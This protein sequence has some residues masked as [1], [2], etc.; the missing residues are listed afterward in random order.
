MI[1][2]I[3]GGMG[4]GK[5]TI[6]NIFRCLGYPVFNSDYEAKH[7]AGNSVRVIEWLNTYLGNS[8]FTNGVLNRAYIAD[9]LFNNQKLLQQ[10]NQLVHPLV[11]EKFEIWKENKQG[12]IFKESALLIESGAYKQT[13]QIIMVTSPV[14]LRIQRVMNRDNTTRE[15][16]MQRISKQMPD[17]EKVNFAHHV[18]NNDDKQAL[19]P[20]IENILNKLHGIFL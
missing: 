11:A 16:V 14:E 7:I 5:T 13:H 2:G 3:T 4:S 8:A 1:V 12:I 17:E 6:S 10:Y 19:L 9:K 20:Q 18:I 15:K